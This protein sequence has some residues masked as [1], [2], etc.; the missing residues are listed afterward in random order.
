MRHSYF[1]CRSFLRPQPSLLEPAYSRSP[2]SG[3]GAEKSSRKKGLGGRERRGRN[4]PLSQFL[5]FAFFFPLRSILRHS[6]LSEHLKQAITRSN[7]AI[8]KEIFFSATQRTQRAVEIPE[9]VL[10][11]QG[12]SV[13]E[14]F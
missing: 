4:R 13:A 11:L 9:A 3:D 5:S 2:D 7:A 1:C 12:V 8:H 10:N 6:P 14:F